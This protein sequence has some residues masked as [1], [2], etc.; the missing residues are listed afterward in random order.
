[1]V[2][3]SSGNNLKLLV[4][5]TERAFLF[6]DFE[7]C[8]RSQK[9]VREFLG[10]EILAYLKSLGKAVGAEHWDTFLKE[11]AEHYPDKD[12]LLYTYTFAFCNP[13]LALRAARWLDRKIKSR[14]RK[15]FSKY[16]AAWKLH[17]LLRST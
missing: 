6:F 11:T 5:I 14:A 12:L 3:E 16:N 7:M 13:N 4:F 9:R 8:Y 10:R 17:E 1:M 15:P 2:H